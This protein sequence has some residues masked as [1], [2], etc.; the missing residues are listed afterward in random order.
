MNKEAVYAE[1]LQRIEALVDGEDDWITI[2][3]TISCELFHAFDA[4]NW[5]GFYRRVDDQTLKVGPYQGGHGCLTIDVNRGVCGKCVREAAIQLEN[6]VA[7]L[8]FHIAC[9]S[10]TQSEIVLPICDDNG[11][12][13]AVLDVDSPVLDQ[14]DEVDVAYLTKIAALAKR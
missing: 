14:F 1:T 13:Q 3:S 6:N 12:V 7:K 11:Y 9:S 5:V 10:E 8:P 2:A 4:F